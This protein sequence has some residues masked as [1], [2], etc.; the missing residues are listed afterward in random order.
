MKNKLLLNSLTLILGWTI[1]FAQ[2]GLDFNSHTI[3]D[4]LKLNANAVIRQN[5]TVIT[6]EDYD[7]VEVIKDRVVTVFNKAGNDAVDAIESYDSSTKIKKIEAIVYDANGEKID[8]FK[9]SDFKDVS[10]VGSGTLY[11]DNRVKYLDYTPRD[12]PYTI[13]FKSVVVLNS[14]AFLPVWMPLENYFTSTELSSFKV[15]NKSDTEIKYKESNLEDYSITK[16]DFLD[17]TAS[18][19]S[20]IDYQS[21]SPNF[22]TYGPLVKIALKRF[23]MQG[24]DGNNNEWSDF[25]KWMNN[26]LLSDVGVLPDGVKLEIKELTRNAKTE[27]E[28]AKIVYEFMQDR[29]RYIS[30]QVGIGGWKP[31]KAAE[32][33]DLAYGDCKGLSNY[34]KALLNEV[35][36]TS[37]HA[38]IY[39][40]N[41]IRDIDRD[42]SST[43]GNHMI[44][45]IPQ[46][47]DE[48]NV[49]L[50]C[51]SKINPF[52]YIAGF[53]D[54]RDALVISENGGEILHTTVYETEE[55]TQESNAA[56]QI[57]KDG[58][59][60][61]KIEMVTKGYQYSFRDHLEKYSKKDL[62]KKYKSY[63]SHLNGLSITDAS[64]MND[65]DKIQ[66]I[67][68]ANVMVSRYG[69]KTGDLLL[70]QPVFFNRN[71]SEPTRYR[72]RQYD[73]EIDRG[74]ID[75]DTYEIELENGLI[76][77]ALPEPVEIDSK[78]G[79]YKLSIID[80]GDGKLKVSRYL[81]IN[82]GSF[83]KED[84]DAYREFR[85]TLVKHD[86][87]KAVLKIN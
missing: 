59:A 43:Q 80:E 51:T 14:T 10:S 4:N 19:L 23:K 38:V 3:S 75:I 58:S 82:K 13:H 66:V 24:V 62:I 15:I 60:L 29:S 36:I 65:K 78:F 57:L 47:D 31:I 56:I 76:V 69:S 2:Q 70:I 41:N 8:R 30:V 49:W 37:H 1:C 26:K 74:Y 73:L 86:K 32:V 85:A 27:K 21:Y 39:G 81:R 72:N 64:A 61:A 53:T 16:N 5:N 33:H 46:L 11:S 28:K 71:E 55:N 18:N 6:V 17:Y 22:N 83:E 12:F 44:L 7:K 50:E 68:N 42:F 79:I 87:S 67:E 45:Y 54:D 40:G 77:E 20:A 35:G 63:W 48:E 25:G 34:T 9:S 52:G 84:Y